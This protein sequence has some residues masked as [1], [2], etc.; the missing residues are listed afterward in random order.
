MKIVT[1]PRKNVDLPE[2]V[3]DFLEKDTFRKQI[4]EIVEDF[5]EKSYNNSKPW[6]SSRIMRVKTK[7]FAM[8]GDFA[9]ELLFCNS[10][11]FSSLFF[12]FLNFLHF[13]SFS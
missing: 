11:H 12:I 2:L 9:F 5:I 7:T 13:S 8:F 3:V 10:L 4:I 6:K 1:F